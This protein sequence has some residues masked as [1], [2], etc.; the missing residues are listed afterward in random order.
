MGRPRRALARR[1]RALMITCGPIGFMRTLAAALVFASAAPLA[2]AQVHA[3]APASDEAPRAPTIEP[4]RS[5]LRA[6]SAPFLTEDESRALRLEHG[7][8]TEADL[9]DPRWAAKAA[10][11]VGAWDHPSLQDEGADPLDRAEALVA[12]GEGEAALDLLNDLDSIRALRL[13]AESLLVLGRTEDA[14]R[15]AARAVEDRASM[16]GE[17]ASA[18]VE[19]LRAGLVRTRVEGA[20]HAAGDFHGIIGALGQAR[21]GAPLSWRV[22]LLEAEVLQAKSNPAEARAAITEALRHHPRLAPAWRLIAEQQVDT[23]GFDAATAIAGRLD[24]LTGELDAGPSAAGALVRARA[25]LRVGDPE[26]AERELAGVLERFPNHQGALSLHAAAAARA[27]D[28]DEAQRR[29]DAFAER[30]PGLA[31]AALAVGVALSDARQYAEASAFLNR[32]V[33]LEPNRAEGWIELGMLEMQWGR[34]SA[35]LDALRTAAR[36]DPF[37][38]RVDNALRLFTELLTYDT[39]D[40]EHFRV[41]F[42]PGIDRVLA[43]E[44]LVELEAM[45]ERVTGDAPGSIRHVPSERTLIELMPDH[46]WFSV[47]ITG[48]PKIFTVAAAT[49]RVIAMESP[50]S[51]PRSSTG[52]YDWLRV[53]RHEYVH[54]VTLSRTNNRIPHWLTEA[55]AVHLED[56]PRDE[57]RARLL[58]GAYA[59]GELFTMDRINLGFIRPEKPT[60]RALA[61]AQSHW[62]YEF[63]IERFGDEAPLRFMDAVAEG[64][65]QPRAFE[66]A[67][68][69]READF[70]ES[71]MAW[72]GEQVVAWGLALPRGVPSVE[73]LRTRAAIAAMRDDE[74]EQDAPAR[75]GFVFDPDAEPVFDLG[76]I[77]TIDAD[78]LPRVTP[79]QLDAWLDEHPA[80]PKL[81]GLKVRA[82]LE[83]R[84]GRPDAS[85]LELLERYAEARPVAELPHRMLVTLYRSG[86]AIASGRSPEGVIPHLEWLD[87]REVYSPVYAIELARLYADAGARTPALEKAERAVRI[88]PF[89]AEYRDFAARISL[90]QRDI[91]RAERHIRALTV[92]EPDEPMHRARLERLRELRASEH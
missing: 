13:R 65:L 41:R 63:M 87:V 53:V 64:L 16:S 86:E 43:E 49:G 57:Q 69:V 47:R 72:A 73:A 45:H 58:A 17:D 40:S 23:F 35:A 50:K 71:F 66:N 61:Y 3:T 88:S 1:G 67:L 6:V 20:Q 39:L 84:N 75:R 82:E 90:V 76:P 52:P 38:T 37:H 32:A 4:A 33:E 31:D 7:L 55:A 15:E 21:Q 28:F 91:P 26:T 78:S 83:R 68:G 44:M 79:A 18:L 34:D 42:R 77:T 62:M 8:W 59:A 2:I 14:A 22:R 92:L 48:M 9:S 89:N 80:H 5:L 74:G 27:F 36:L 51:G 10:I 11:A 25:A 30:S 85:M 70:Y 56:A 29:V 60:D 19:A 12:I 46:A 81:L 54:T 24:E